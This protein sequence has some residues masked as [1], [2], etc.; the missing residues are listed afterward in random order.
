MHCE[1]IFRKKDHAQSIKSCAQVLL[2][3]DSQISVLKLMAPPTQEYWMWGGSRTRAEKI[4]SLTQHNPNRLG[5]SDALARNAFCLIGAAAPI[6]SLWARRIFISHGKPTSL[7]PEL[8]YVYSPQ[9]QI[10][11][12]AAPTFNGTHTLWRAPLA[13]LLQCKY[14]RIPRSGS[15]RFDNAPLPNKLNLF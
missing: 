5:L 15:T 3:R 11:N 6:C 8:A 2:W 9:S 10:S 7:S 1:Y 4:S 13:K 14:C 12:C